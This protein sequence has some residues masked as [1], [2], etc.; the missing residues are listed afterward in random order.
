M[1][2]AELLA[3]ST[4]GLPGG[5][6]V[7]F[8]ALV[9]AIAV[10]LVMERFPSAW[11][12]WDP[13]ELSKGQ[14]LTE[15]PPPAEVL[16]PGPIT[17]HVPK[18]TERPAPGTAAKLLDDGH[19][20][21]KV[22]KLR[23]RR[24]PQGQVFSGRYVAYIKGQVPSPTDGI[25]WPDRVKPWKDAHR[26]A[27]GRCEI[28]VV[29][30]RGG[31]PNCGQRF[32]LESMD[33]DHLSYANLYAETRRDVAFGCHEDHMRREALKRQGLDIYEAWGTPWD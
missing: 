22:T 33:S 30:E 17:P 21:G 5:A 10:L 25:Y 16:P 27:G 12:L 26:A 29:L 13:P 11:R 4:A 18:P 28:A 3:K 20:N 15:A 24:T 23:A 9:V 6:V 31:Q 14:D 32:V 7:A 1:P 2:V 8:T 19:G